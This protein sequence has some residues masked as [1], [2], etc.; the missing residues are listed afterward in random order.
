MIPKKIHYCWFGGNPLPETAKKYM[1]T[2]KKYCPDYEIIEWNEKNFDI[3][4]NQYCQEAYKAKKW[5]FVSD[6]ARLKVLYEYGGIYMDTDVEVV[7]PFDDLLKEYNFF[8]CVEGDKISIGTFG[9]IAKNSYIKLLLDKYQ[10]R[11]FIKENGKFDYTT[12]LKIVT[13]V[14]AQKY[15]VDFLKFKNNI[16]FGNKNVIF[17]QD[18]FI[19][20]DYVTGTLQVTDNTFAIH[21]F[22][23]SWLNFLGKIKIIMQ[24]CFCFILGTKNWIKLKQFLKK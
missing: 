9:T 12:N 13:E 8:A 2:W 18:Y 16:I 6:Y 1:N 22:D 4:Q 3:T 14:T 19:A 17:T 23:G 11:K 24:R 20:K 21:H 7:K 10:N 15:K 5:A